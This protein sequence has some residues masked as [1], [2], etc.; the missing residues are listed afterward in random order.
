MVT[1][2]AAWR[3]GLIPRHRLFKTVTV[4][5]MKT[6]INHHNWDFQSYQSLLKVET[7]VLLFDAEDLL[8][9][10]ISS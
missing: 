7:Q 5:N 10:L 1:Y 8:G 4:W 2:R 3:F 6:F 9:L